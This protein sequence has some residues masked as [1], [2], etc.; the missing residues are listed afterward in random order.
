TYLRVMSRFH[1]YSW[2]NCLMIFIQCPDATH[3]AGFH[4]WLKMRRFVRKGENAIVI[5]APMVGHKKSDS[6]ISED[7]QTRLFGFRAAHVFDVS[8]TDG[9]PLPEFATVRGDPQGYS[10]PSGPIPAGFRHFTAHR[11][12]SPPEALLPLTRRVARQ[13]LGET[14]NNG[15][16]HQ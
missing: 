1:R 12:S 8:Q 5:L 13:T 16:T 11:S 6:E 3:V 7:G 9:E 10:P 4:A 14:I 15:G 2:G